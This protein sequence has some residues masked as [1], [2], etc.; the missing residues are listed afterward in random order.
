[1]RE[2]KI[3]D[4]PMRALTGE[5]LRRIVMIEGC[6]PGFGG[7]EDPVVSDFNNTMFGDSCL[8]EYTSVRKADGKVSEMHCFYFDYDCGGFFYVKDPYGVPWQSRSKRP[9][10]ATLAYLISEGFDIPL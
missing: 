2:I 6:C 7:W 1:M 8:I 3:G 4:K 10:L 9:S 5:D